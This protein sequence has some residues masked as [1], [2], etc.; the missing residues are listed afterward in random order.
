MNSAPEMV[1]RPQTPRA[2]PALYWALA[3][4]AVIAG[5]QLRQTPRV[6]DE[7]ITATIQP[8]IVVLMFRYI[9]GGAIKTPDG[10][11]Y[12]NYL[13]P[14]AFI[15]SAILASANTG[16][17]LANDL[18]RGLVDR[19]RSLPMARSAIITGRVVADIARNSI[20]IVVTWAVGLLVGF[21]PT[22]APLQWVAATAL[23]LF[24][25][26]VFSWLAA[27]MGLLI[28]T[29]EAVAQA[30]ILWLLPFLLGSSAFVPVST[31]PSWLQAFV[32]HQPVSLTMDA[33]R[34]LLLGHTDSATIWLALA[35]LGGL[36]VLLIPLTLWTY[37]RRT[38]R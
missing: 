2:R 33:A 8:I 17:S 34:G 31:M 24:T 4:A 38:A 20:I 35:W 28:P 36:L 27:L 19:F 3:D 18:Q 25:S 16:V 7:L 23:A 13:M 10:V 29:P 11:S 1:A 30:G 15:Y 22:G 26:F 9:F 6:P 37:A 5:R 21:R 32:T 14:G 12:I